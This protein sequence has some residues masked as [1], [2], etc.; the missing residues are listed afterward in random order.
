[1]TI[2]REDLLR[3][4]FRSVATGEPIPPAHP[5]AVL[6]GDFMAPNCLSVDA[7][8]VAL[9]MRPQHVLD[10][11]RRHRAIS[12]ETALRLARY[13]GTSGEFWTGLQ[14]GYALRLARAAAGAA[15][16]RDVQPL[17]ATGG[18]IRPKAAAAVTAAP[19][20]Q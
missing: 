9:R 10:I 3:T 5:G 13:F 20:R 14:S 8:A 2:K 18:D 15:I 16:D 12:S 6:E 7:L 17:A 11:V 19:P 1:M 4:D